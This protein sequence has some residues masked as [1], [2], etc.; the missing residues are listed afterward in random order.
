M[1]SPEIKSIP[2]LA[3][4]LHRAEL[5]FPI[6]KNFLGYTSLPR[7]PIGDAEKLMAVVSVRLM[8]VENYPMQG[9]R[10]LVINHPD[11]RTLVPALLALVRSY[12]IQTGRR[13]LKFLMGDIM[14]LKVN[15]GLGKSFYKLACRGVKNFAAT[16]P[17]NIIP[18]ITNRINCDYGKTRQLA[19]EAVVNE[20]AGGAV[21]VLAPEGRPE[22]GNI[23][24][25][26]EVPRYGAGEIAIGIGNLCIPVLPVAIWK[27]KE[28]INLNIGPDFSPARNTGREEVM[29]IMQKIA[30]LLPSR[31]RGPY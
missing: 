10:L 12:N 14:P 19:R 25:G 5:F 29:E 31:L 9:G 30:V 24:L 4:D 20:I 6:L 16:Y 11:V 1:I 17:D 26:R 23:L 2:K 8:G 21:V 27:E 7:D 13:D 18:T 15:N 28:S 22:K 3:G